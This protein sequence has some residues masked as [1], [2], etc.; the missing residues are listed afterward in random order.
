MRTKIFFITFI[1]FLHLVSASPSQGARDTCQVISI[2][3]VL[4]YSHVEVEL[5]VFTDDWLG[6]VTIPLT[7]DSVSTDIRCDSIHWSDW[8][9]DAFDHIWSYSTQPDHDYIDTTKQEIEIWS[10]W[11]SPHGL[12]PKD[13]TLATIHFTIGEINL[14]QPNGGEEWRVEEARM[15]RWSPECDWNAND[16]VLIDSFRMD[17]QQGTPEIP[18]VNFSDTDGL[19]TDSVQFRHG[20]LS[21]A[22]QDW[23]SVKIEYS[24]DAG[25]T[26]N[27]I[28][29]STLNDA[30]YLWS[31][32][33]DTPSDSCLVRITSKAENPISVVSDGFFAILAETTDVIEERKEHS[34]PA[35]F[36]LYQNY[37]NPFNPS[38]KIEFSLPERAQV[39]LEIYNISG[40]RVKRLVD[41]E[42]PSGQWSVIWDGEDDKGMEVAS[43]IYFYRLKT[44]QFTQTRK[45][46]LIR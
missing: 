30:E 22:P 11:E 33:P 17:S 13:T 38:T 2:D 32:V 25:R 24:Y 45:M 16:S 18:P 1:V 20:Y 29:S 4:P 15:I 37:P 36:I 44:S 8:F 19:P 39:T 10:I 3:N 26:W 6:A 46:V 7:W 27:T 34:F 42:L 21:R 5:R 31:P 23:D 35:T 43:G 14:I 12:V 41:E 40:K 9:W 28:V